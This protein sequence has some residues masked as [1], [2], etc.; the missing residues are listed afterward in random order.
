MSDR[1]RARLIEAGL[2]LAILAAYVL[3]G[4]IAPV[5]P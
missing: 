1:L 2:I 5:G 4:T 3:A